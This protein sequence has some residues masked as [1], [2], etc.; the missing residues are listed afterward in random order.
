MTQ[1]TSFVLPVD[2]PAGPTSHDVVARARRALGQRRIGHTGTLDPFASGLLLLCVGTATR[3]AEYL[4]DLPKTYHAVARFDGRT[5]TDDNTSEKIDPSDAWRSLS[6]EAVERALR[7]QQGDI[8]QMPPQYSAKKVEGRRAYDIARRGD[9]ATLTAVPVHIERI[10]VRRVQLPEVAFDVTC[11]SGTYIR[12]IARD[13][14][15][16]LGTGGYLTELRRTRI[17]PHDVSR[18]VPLERLDDAAAVSAAALSPLDALAHMPRLELS[19]DETRAVR[20]GQALPKTYE[21]EAPVLLVHEGEL[22]AVAAMQDGRVRP[23]KVFNHG[24]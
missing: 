9:V 20:F 11:S 8:M 16:A 13:A 17:G 15:A 2:K 23:R 12:A 6:G 22:V 3:I 4:T 10:D 18:A 1:A 5:L 24:A 19:A 21:S 14:G 7:A